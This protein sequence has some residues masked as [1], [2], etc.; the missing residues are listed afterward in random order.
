MGLLKERPMHD[1]PSK[2]NYYPL[3]LI[4][5]RLDGA[6]IARAEKVLNER[7]DKGI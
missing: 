3:R 1:V 7:N 6:V 5:N 4:S 2:A